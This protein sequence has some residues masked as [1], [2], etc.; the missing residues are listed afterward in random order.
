MSTTL[1]PDPHKSFYLNTSSCVYSGVK[2]NGRRGGNLGS[3][4]VPAVIIPSIII[5][6]KTFALLPSRTQ[7]TRTSGAVGFIE[8]FVALIPMLDYS[9]A[10]LCCE[11]NGID[12]LDRGRHS[13]EEHVDDLQVNDIV[14]SGFS[15]CKERSAQVILL[16]WIWKIKINTKQRGNETMINCTEK[17]QAK[18]TN[19]KVISPRP[20]PP[21]RRSYR[22]SRNYPKSY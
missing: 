16:K 7:T 17:S 12:G 18:F 4:T 10:L 3:M 11:I 1:Y 14:G 13:L 5:P 6:S 21:I 2:G 20:P 8:C 19:P 15:I 9:W 22:S